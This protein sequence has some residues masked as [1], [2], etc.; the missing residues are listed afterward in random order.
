MMDVLEVLENDSGE[1]TLNFPDELIEEMRWREGDLLDWR[2]KGNSIVL[3]KVNDPEG[4][5]PVE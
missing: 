1:L 2:L 4:Y 5:V 3:S